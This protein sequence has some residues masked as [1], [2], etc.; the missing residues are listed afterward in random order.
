MNKR[1]YDNYIWSAHHLWLWND[2]AEYFVSIDGMNC[3][4]FD[5]VSC[6]Q[7]FCKGFW[8]VWSIWCWYTAILRQL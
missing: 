1:I 3:K 7:R 5:M 2:N 8:L 4:R 6:Y